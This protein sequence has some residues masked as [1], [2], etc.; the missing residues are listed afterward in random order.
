MALSTSGAAILERGAVTP[1]RS[2]SSI[3]GRGW[4]PVVH[5]LSKSE[6]LD[7]LQCFRRLWWQV[8]GPSAEEPA[9]SAERQ[10]RYE[11]G[12]Q[13]GEVARTY[14][15][16]GVLVD[17]HALGRAGAVAKT[18]A[19][20]ES[21]VSVIYE[22]AFEVEGVFAAVDILELLD[23][24]WSLVEVKSST[25]VKA[26]HRPDVAVQLHVVRA[27]GLEVARC[28]VMTLSRDCVFPD[29]EN[30]FERHDITAQAE[31]L[32]ESLSAEV[33][34][35]RAMLAAGLPS[36]EVGE[37]CSKPYECPFKDRCWSEQPEHHISTLYYGGRLARELEAAGCEL[38]ADIPGSTTLSAP[39]ERQVRAVRDN[40][41]V[42]DD[43]LRAAL[44]ALPEPVG[45]L[46]FETVGPAI[47]LWPGCRPYDAVP[48]QFV[49]YVRDEG[50]V[51]HQHE[52]LADGEGDPR[53]DLARQ[54]VEACEGADVLLAWY[55]SFEKR[56]I[57][58]LAEAVPEL[59]AALLGLE[60]RVVDLLPIVRDHVYHPGFGGSF[61]L[62]AV[63]PTLVPEL[64]YE[65]FE[66]RG[67]GEASLILQRLLLRPGEVPAAERARLRA[68]LSEYCCLDTWG[69][70][71]LHET[72]LALAKDE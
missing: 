48:A 67:G 12:L 36:V 26:P 33:G 45:Y 17:R 29:L 61:S 59:S 70:V 52:W 60:E 39:Q 42:C 56:C 31:A 35:Q 68:A 5:D 65:D 9:G 50:G 32:A 44:A 7:G 24:R 63:L 27:A 11:E 23:G 37:H 71:R 38:V 30:L 14:I 22:A 62:K 28:E 3:V 13:V 47:P 1:R 34:A 58:M 19:L 46:D 54:L 21:G 16:E 64:S 8:H 57:R 53:P 72:L 66:I 43:G 41:L 4:G 69:L 6:V 40:A 49:V 18:R 20:V 25:G 51:P 15:P 10:A 55:A 2:L